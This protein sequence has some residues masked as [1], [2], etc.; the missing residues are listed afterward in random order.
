MPRV[1]FSRSCETFRP[2][3]PSEEMFHPSHL[4]LQRWCEKK[5]GAKTVGSDDLFDFAA[6]KIGL[7]LIT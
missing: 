3:H 6:A 1:F 2:R 4:P 5:I 7:F